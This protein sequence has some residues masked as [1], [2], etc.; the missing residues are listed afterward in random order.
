M[1]GKQRRLANEAS[2][3]QFFESWDPAWRWIL[4]LGL[5]DLRRSPESLGALASEEASGHESWVA[6]DYLF[7]PLAVGLTGA[8]LN[9][10]AQHCEDLFALLRV[11][12]DPHYF[13]R[14][15]AGYKAGTTVEFGRR[16]KDVDDATASRMFLV[17]DA[18]T[19]RSG[20]AKSDD[21]EHA[22]R[23]VEDARH[24]LGEMLRQV[25]T[26]YGDI[27]GFHVQ[28]KHGLK[29][30]FRPWGK[31]TEE[32]I[33]RRRTSVDT[34]IYIHTNEPIAAM[35]RRGPGE[36]VMAFKLTDDQR[37]HLPALVEERNILR[38][39]LRHKVDLDEVADLSFTIV[40]LLRLAQT[41]RLSLGNVN[42]DGQ[43]QFSLPAGER[44]GQVDS[45]IEI[46]RVLALSDFA[47]PSRRRGKGRR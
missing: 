8:A 10:A 43:Q 11:L 29:I 7:G 40:R 20:F 14:E 42:D 22:V 12:R 34:P 1:D 47:E 39:R 44:W 31:V 45:S 23:V 36:Q 19:V 24:C 3:R 4:I 13:A 33:Q 15:M 28:Y 46:D 26:F 35:M 37:A 9:E 6:D 5:R 16:L 17:P 38:P 18:Q 41:N 27:E 2:V 30:L 25:A 32:E 21:P